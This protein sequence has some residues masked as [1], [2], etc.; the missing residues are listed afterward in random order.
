MENEI[1][2]KTVCEIETRIKSAS[3]SEREAATTTSV[4]VTRPGSRAG[5]RV[6]SSE[7]AK[8]ERG[9][10]SCLLLTFQIGAIV[11]YDLRHNKYVRAAL[12]GAIVSLGSPPRRSAAAPVVYY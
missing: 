7:P 1:K 9:R 2:V 5:G 12:N 4:T 3:A 10:T 6:L 11:F 8:E